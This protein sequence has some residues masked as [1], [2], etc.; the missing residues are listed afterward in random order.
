MRIA[1]Q[2]ITISANPAM[3]QKIVRQ[4]PNNRM[5]A[6][7]PGAMIGIAMNTMKASDMICAIARPA[8]Q[9]RTIAIIPMR[10]PAIAVP[11]K[12]R[13]ASNS[14]KLAEIAASTFSA[15]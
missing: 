14:G 2:T 6:P 11:P 7:S 3:I 15:A 4:L 13:A 8:K 12:K 10:D 1:T 5:P 9:S